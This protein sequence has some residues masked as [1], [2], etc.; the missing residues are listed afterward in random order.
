[1]I[2]MLANEWAERHQVEILTLDT[3]ANAPFYP[4]DSRLSHRSLNL[5]GPSR[6]PLHAVIANLRRIFKLRRAIKR[7]HP[8]IVVSLMLDTNVTTILASIR[9]SAPVVVCEHADP[10]VY[11]VSPTWNSLR[12]L[13]YRLADR[14]IVLN[15]EMA[16]WFR[17]QVGCD[18]RVIGNPVK[19]PALSAMNETASRQMVAVGRLDEL[20]SFSDL[21][22]A[23][24]LLA[25]QYPDWQLKI[26]GKGPLEDALQAQID[27]TG[28]SSRISLMGITNDIDSVLRDAQLFVSSSTTEAFPMAICEAMSHALCVVST[29][30]GSG[31]ETLIE[32][33]QSGLLCRVQDIDD[34]ADKMAMAMQSPELRQRLGSSARES[35]KRYSLSTISAQWEGMFAE[36]TGA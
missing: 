7:A 34:L 15:E 32:N 4:L 6:N 25:K 27:Q 2:S 12:K 31:V 26:Y 22:S 33:E 36:M 10:M 13:T 28:L 14:L 24:T 30:A 16:T 23:F 35:I 9:Q 19:I 11:P 18:A 5:L 20:K 8:D 21:I 1:M 17:S 3:D 29:R